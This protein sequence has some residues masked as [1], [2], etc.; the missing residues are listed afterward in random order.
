M[1]QGKI[2][3]DKGED[4]KDMLVFV[5]LP[6]NLTGMFCTS[7]V[8]YI[9]ISPEAKAHFIERL[10]SP[11]KVAT[12]FYGDFEIYG[13][14][15]WEHGYFS[16]KP[17]LTAD[18]EIRRT[19]R[20]CDIFKLKICRGLR[21]SV[22]EYMIPTDNELLREL[23][24][25][26]G[27]EEN[28]LWQRHYDAMKDRGEVQGCKIEDI[29]KTPPSFL[30]EEQKKVIREHYRERN[31]EFDVYHRNNSSEEVYNIIVSELMNTYLKS[32]AV[33]KEIIA[34]NG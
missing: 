17:S 9:A 31:E 14:G 11:D 2:Y 16:F 12:H 23:D 1:L 6:C 15:D 8:D 22:L 21:R 24:L 29:K 33:I 20:S 19:L 27:V 4:G 25:V 26:A 5:F 7:S 28:M 13:Y 34:I 3:L 32:E 10:N 18:G 30:T